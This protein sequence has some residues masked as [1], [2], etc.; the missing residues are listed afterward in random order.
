MKSQISS[1]D[2]PQ[3]RQGLPKSMCGKNQ[4]LTPR[5]G[6]FNCSMMFSD[7]LNQ[8]VCWRCA[9]HRV[10]ANRR[11][12][13]FLQI[14]RRRGRI[15]GEIYVNGEPVDYDFLT[16]FMGYVEQRDLHISKQTVYEA[17]LFA[18]RTRLPPDTSDEIA[19][20]FTEYILEIMNLNVDRNRL[21]GSEAQTEASGAISS[22]ARKRLSIAVEYAANASLYFLDEP[23]SGLDARSALRVMRAIRALADNDCAVVSV[24][25]QP[26]FEVFGAFDDLLLM[27]SGGRT[28]YFGELGDACTSMTSYFARNGAEPIDELTNPADY[29]LRVIG[30]G[31]DAG[32]KQGM[33]DWAEIWR[34]APECKQAIEK[35]EELNRTSLGAYKLTYK[36]PTRRQ[37]WRPHLLCHHSAAHFILAHAYLQLFAHGA[38]C[39]SGP[40]DRPLLP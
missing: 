2:L 12:S 32:R 29:M 4:S 33:Q 26:S 35:L 21:V 1:R 18:A 38:G 25:H 34:N 9:A 31:I 13:I 5:T 30:G 39:G 17:V 19:K 15:A 10:P 40:H 36:P 8:A 24:I 11:C 22:D 6:N 23:T 20:Q 7:T 16:H 37:Q 3:R 14:E 28:V 27:R